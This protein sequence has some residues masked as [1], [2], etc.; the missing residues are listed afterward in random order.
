MGGMVVIVCMSTLVVSGSC[1]GVQSIWL[2]IRMVTICASS[3]AA[4][5][6]Q[7]MA[8]RVVFCG[9]WGMLVPFHSI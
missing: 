1:W 8:S 6:A 9:L 5:L 3:L 4:I 7:W 2:I